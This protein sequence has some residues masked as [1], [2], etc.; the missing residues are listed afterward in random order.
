MRRTR[1]ASHPVPRRATRPSS[2]WPRPRRAR[3]PGPC[4][5]PRVVPGGRGN[6]GR[7]FRSR[8]R[9]GVRSPPAIRRPRRVRRKRRWPRTAAARSSGVRQPAWAARANRPAQL[10]PSIVTIFGLRSGGILRIVIGGILRIELSS[11]PPPGQD[12]RWP[13]APD[14]RFRWPGRQFVE[15]LDRRPLNDD[16]FRKEPCLLHLSRPLPAALAGL[17]PVTAA[18][19]GISRSLSY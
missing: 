13:A 2:A 12:D 7:A 9:P 6:A 11:V 4:T 18:T 14:Q 8:R 3:R 1:A 15:A 17:Q 16:R 19:G 10:L 5:P